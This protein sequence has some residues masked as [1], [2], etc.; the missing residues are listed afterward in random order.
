MKSTCY[1]KYEYAIPL[2]YNCPSHCKSYD[3]FP[4][5]YF[6]DVLAVIQLG[7]VIFSPLSGM[8]IDQRRKD[9]RSE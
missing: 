9:Y 3:L 4:V 5:S 7:N 1:H 8:I 2:T 6:T